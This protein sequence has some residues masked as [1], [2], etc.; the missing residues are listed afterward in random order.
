MKRLVW[1]GVGVGVGV[2]LTV[3]ALRQVAKVNTRVTSVAEALRPAGIAAQVAGLAQTVRE[4]GDQL[5]TSMA[6]HEDAL[7]SAVLADEETLARAR[8]VRAARSRRAEDT[9]IEDLLDDPD[10]YF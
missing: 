3:V 2:A 5:R 1:V 9:E 6:E 8:E 7:R 10:R 4:L